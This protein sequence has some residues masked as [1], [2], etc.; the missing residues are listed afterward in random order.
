[1][2][3]KLINFCHHVCSK[4]VNHIGN[5]H[6]RQALQREAFHK[7]VVFT[8]ESGACFGDVVGL[9]EKC[10]VNDKVFARVMGVCDIFLMLTVNLEMLIGKFFVSDNNVWCN[11][12]VGPCSEVYWMSSVT[13]SFIPHL[14]SIG[15]NICI[16]SDYH[17]QSMTRLSNITINSYCE[18][19]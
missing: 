8:D 10:P 12:D 9:G 1:M 13:Y 15:R 7:Y 19:S 16:F 2:F 3:T 5:L 14:Y 18:F 4:V 17:R 6:D 11:A